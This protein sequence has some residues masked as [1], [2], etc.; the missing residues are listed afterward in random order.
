M[1]FG[2]IR[3]AKTMTRFEEVGYPRRGWWVAGAILLGTGTGLWVGGSF[4]VREKLAP[5]IS[6]ELSRTLN[7]P[8]TL[9]KVERFGW[10]GVRFGASTIPATAT[11]PDYLQVQ[12]IEVQFQPWQL[13][14]AR[15]LDIQVNLI[16]PQ[17]VLHQ[18]SDR[19]WLRITPA[20]G[21]ETSP[22]PIQ[23][24]VTQVRLRGGQVTLVPW[25]TRRAQT[26]AQI[27]AQVRPG[28]EQ[29]T[30]Q[31]QAQ[32]PAGGSLRLGGHL[33]FA[34][35]FPPGAPPNPGD[36]TPA[37]GGIGGQ[38]YEIARDCAPGTDDQ[39]PETDLAEW[40]KCRRL[41]DR[42]KCGGGWWRLPNWDRCDRK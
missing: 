17:A 28:T 13:F 3:L 4:F 34:D 2:L 31:T 12:G 35:T 26:Y 7:R 24:Q 8:V 39:R 19:R 33:G 42:C 6:Q 38:L 10:T 22:P 11:D 30:F 16:Q 25:A 23:V 9:G 40:G 5:L 18:S 41:R 1:G 14:Q 20:I 36:G 27:Q 15:R 37:G 21:A 29:I 32:A